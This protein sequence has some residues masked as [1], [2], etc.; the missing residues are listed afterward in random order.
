MN[1][2]EAKKARKQK[3]KEIE[4]QKVEYKIARLEKS[5]HKVARKNLIDRELTIQDYLT[6][7]VYLD[8]KGLVDWSS[9]DKDDLF[10]RY[11]KS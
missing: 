4:G 10:D 6:A 11:D 8:E 7:L 1:A 3:E 2:I 5:F 9:F